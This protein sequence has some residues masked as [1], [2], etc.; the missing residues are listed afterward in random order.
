MRNVLKH[1]TA[2]KRTATYGFDR[3]VGFFVNIEREGMLIAEYDRLRPG[4][5]ELNGA[6]RLLVEQGFL[7]AADI[8]EAVRLCPVLLPAE[9]EP[10]AGRAA[11]VIENLRRA[12]DPNPE[13]AAAG[14]VPD[15]K[16]S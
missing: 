13:L 11:E 3:A 8:D 5:G 12:A 15:E 16:G 14:A 10:G 7:Q 6:L 2:R 9:M 4:Y 1:P